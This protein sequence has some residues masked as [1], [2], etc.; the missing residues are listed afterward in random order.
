MRWVEYLKKK[1]I[2]FQNVSF[3]PKNS[4]SEFT[5]SV[6]IFLSEYHSSEFI[7]ILCA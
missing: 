4:F 1:V 2:F 3:L 5:K 7:D 6:K